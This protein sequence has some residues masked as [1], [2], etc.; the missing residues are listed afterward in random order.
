MKNPDL[1]RGD[2]RKTSYIGEKTDAILLWRSTSASSGPRPDMPSI[3]LQA[4][5]R[6]HRRGQARAEQR[7]F[8]AQGPKRAPP[9]TAGL[10]GL[11]EID[12]IPVRLLESATRAPRH[13]VRG[14][15]TRSPRA[16]TRPNR[17]VTFPTPRSRTF[18][19]SRSA[20]E[21][22]SERPRRPPR[23]VRRYRSAGPRERRAILRDAEISTAPRS[24]L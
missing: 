8:S 19:L 7:R 9:E 18:T 2:S 5:G 22:R 16:S 24:A 17:P 6:P 4:R 10:D 21:R 23:P 11:G 13:F 14:P 12:R 20:A 1:P 3:T 15:S